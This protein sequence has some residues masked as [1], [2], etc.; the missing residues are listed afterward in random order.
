MLAGRLDALLCVLVAE[1][2]AAQSAMR[3][4]GTP[5][6]SWLAM[7]GNLS[8]KES[9]GLLFKAQALA[10]NEAVQE[11]AL[12]GN[13][14]TGQA[15][16]IGRV[17]DELPPSLD[18]SQREQA[19]TALL[20]YANSFD[21]G[22][23]AAM[24]SQVL[25]QV[26]PA[27]ADEQE[28]ERLQRQAQTARRNRSLCFVREHMGSVTFRGSLPIVDAEGWIAIIDS[29]VES[30]R[31]TVLEQRDPLAE[32]LSPQQ[33]RA[34]ALLAMIR[35][36]TSRRMA[37]SG[38][39]DRPRVVVT[40]NYVAL[41]QRAVDAGAITSG[42]Q[43]S[44]SDL[45]RLCCDADVIPAVLGGP[46]EVL[47]VGRAQRLVT[48]GIRAALVLRDSG[49]V[50]PGCET[51]PTAC[52][53]HHI[54]P[55]RDGGCTDLSNLALLC[56]HHHGL[57]EPD[58]YGARDQWL[59]RIAADGVPEFVP[60]R[61]VDPERRPV[62]HQRFLRRVV[63][64]PVGPA[65]EGHVGEPHQIDTATAH[66]PVEPRTVVAV[67]GA[68]QLIG[69]DTRSHPGERPIAQPI[70]GAHHRVDAAGGA[71]DTENRAGPAP[72]RR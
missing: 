43:I 34:D 11:A 4:K 23:L 72:P 50:F 2:D 58:R 16:A 14:G 53:A 60:P 61:R 7:S 29:Y 35:D 54:Q 67:Q 65:R 51:H 39:G 1:A 47:D 15:R 12:A 18:E 66:P 42:Q 55:W 10:A 56:H 46:S 28:A 21:A 20:E 62:R 25:R 17:L 44:A 71:R 5:S 64:H 19:A 33:R 48:R 24:S 13:I 59:T 70:Q 45:R 52:E 9:A 6:T 22:Q 30:Q 69:I 38:G 40:M 26:S 3:A 8:K 32:P 37:P 63:E 36:H 49:C 68:Q 57:V 41:H 27:S 31:R